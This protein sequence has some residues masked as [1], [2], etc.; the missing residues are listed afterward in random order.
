ML[1]NTETSWGLL[2]RSLHWLIALL[3]F[4]LFGYGLWMNDFVPREERAYHYAIHA[5]VGISVLALMILRL[6][7]R[8]MNPTPASSL[9]SAN[10]EIKVAKL[11][12][13]GLYALAFGVLIAGYFL[14]GTLKTPVDVKLFDLFSMP[15]PLESGSPYRGF[16]GEAHELLAWSVVG[17][18]ALH[19]AAAI[20]HERVKRD[21]VLARM[22]SGRSSA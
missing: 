20:W 9:G 8:L 19:A 4:G 3:I 13:F 7:W 16:L 6:V 2:A 11:A 12:H 5:A 21:G 15:A 10:W 18:A 17:L 14:A 22:T 1:R